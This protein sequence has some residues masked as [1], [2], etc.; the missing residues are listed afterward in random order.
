[1]WLKVRT[2]KAGTDGRRHQQITALFPWA[3]EAPEYWPRQPQANDHNGHVIS[4]PLAAR[5]KWRLQE[6]SPG[7]W[8]DLFANSPDDL[9]PETLPLSLFG[10]WAGWI[11]VGTDSEKERP[12]KAIPQLSRQEENEPGKHELIAK[13]P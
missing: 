3:Q 9:P 12:Q 1:M 4:N 5:C 10:D 2:D 8:G 6:R 7:R 11:K 13:A